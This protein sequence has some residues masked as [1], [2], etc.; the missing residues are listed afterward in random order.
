MTD[1]CLSVLDAGSASPKFAVCL[2]DDGL[3]LAQ[4]GELVRIVGPARM[5]I[6]GGGNTLHEAAL[7]VPDHAAALGGT[8]PAA[9]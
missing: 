7:A 1:R 6:T 8:R 5:E 3:H 2:T 4:S 9:G